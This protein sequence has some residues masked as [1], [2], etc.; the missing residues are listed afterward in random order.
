MSVKLPVAEVEVTIK[1][2]LTRKDFKKYQ[3]VLFKGAKSTT[4]GVLDQASLLENIEEQ[5][6]EL[7][8]VYVE[9]YGDKDITKDIIENLVISDYDLL[10]AECQKKY[11][12][13]TE[14]K[15]SKA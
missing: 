4:S 7:I 10:L 13:H 1:E 8:L 12:K 3:S 11:Q 15:S 2:S 6:D 5:K 14:K 9:K